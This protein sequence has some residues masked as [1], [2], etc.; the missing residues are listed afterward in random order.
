MSLY[1]KYNSGFTLVELLIVV[2]IIGILAV[3]VLAAINPIEQFNKTRDTGRKTDAGQIL[4]ALERYYTNN[5]QFPWNASRAEVRE[6]AFGVFAGSTVTTTDG[7]GWDNNISPANVLD[8][9][10]AQGELKDSFVDDYRDGDLSVFEYMYVIKPANSTEITVC[11][12]PESKAMRES[13]ALK[14]TADSWADGTV[15]DDLSN[16]VAF[17]TDDTGSDCDGDINCFVCIPPVN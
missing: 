4:N 12:S 11:F 8:A 5:R 1:S 9:L 17:G 6:A 2:T 16:M 3:A 7:D 10:V 14:Y 13:E 15:I